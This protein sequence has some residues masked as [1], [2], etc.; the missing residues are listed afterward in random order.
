MNIPV[1]LA[2]VTLW[3]TAFIIEIYQ[4][5]SV[6]FS[7]SKTEKYFRCSTMTSGTGNKKSKLTSRHSNVCEKEREEHTAVKKGFVFVHYD[8][9]ANEDYLQ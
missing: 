8:K 9:R 3:M 1:T 2:F 7:N 4:L 5:S 6:R